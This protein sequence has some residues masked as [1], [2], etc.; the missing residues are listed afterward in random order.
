MPLLL[1]LL[2]LVKE[3]KLASVLLTFEQ[4]PQSWL[5]L[6]PPLKLRSVNQSE[7][8]KDSK[9]SLRLKLIFDCAM[10]AL[11]YTH[12]FATHLQVCVAAN[13]PIQASAFATA[14][15][16]SVATALVE[17]F[18]SATAEFCN[19]KKTISTDTIY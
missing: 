12:N 3:T 5:Q 2:V 11:G 7:P 13:G 17:A 1:Q 14:A 6:L 15:Q 16:T 10:I 8:L 4:L 19:S 9:S 18:A